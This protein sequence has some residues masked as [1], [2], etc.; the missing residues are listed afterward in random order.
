MKA[1]ADKSE[2]VAV[3]QE[4]RKVNLKGLLAKYSLVLVFLLLFVLASALSPDFLTRQNLTNLLQQSALIGIVSVGMTFVILLGGIDL[5]VGSVAAFGG[6]AVA[7]LI[8][9]GWNP[10]LAVL[11]ALAAGAVF[12]AMIGGISSFW[13]VPA[14]MISLAGLTGVRGLTYLTTNGTPVGGMPAGFAFF[15]NGRIGA[16]PVVGIVFIVI[17]IIASI[18]LKYT[19]FG[20]YLY[21]TGGNQEAARLSGVPTKIVY[22][23]GFIVSGVLAALAGV[24]LTA[25]LTIGQPTAASGWELD[26]I[27]AVVLGGTSLNGGRGGIFGT[28]LAVFLLQ[29]VRNIFNLM[30]LGSFFQMVTTG[31]ILIVAIVLNKVIESRRHVE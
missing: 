19:V 24:L 5:S 31:I 16:V 10:A 21:A 28:V 13:N 18:V 17:A 8:E 25:R 15:G 27:A 20:E 23:I 14:F 12:G 2:A 9:S 3:G 26:A 22:T 1:V 4:R 30:G 6:M 7:I 11:A 29:V